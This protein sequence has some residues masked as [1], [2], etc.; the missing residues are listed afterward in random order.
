MK[1][2]LHKND[3]PNR[4]NFSKSIAI[5]T[6]TM[7]LNPA[8][9]RLC[10]VQISNGNGV[11]H[12]VQIFDPLLRPKNLISLLK[13]KKIQKIFHY[14]RFDVAILKYTYKINI[15]NIYCTKIASKL[16][17]TFTDKHGY[18]DLCFDLLNKKISKTQQTTDWGSKKL[19]Q[20]QQKYAATDVLYLHKIK[21]EL[22][23][24]L[25]RENRMK[26]ANACF[27]FIKIRTDLDLFGW[28]EQDIF[29]H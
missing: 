1:I 25:I 8:R 14:A 28:A 15:E 29:K 16:T 19:S 7:G 4:L 22:D 12:L 18:Q 20:A 10:L 11:C 13:N 17:R 27:D 5:D 2:E 21:N 26:I 23:K 24:I 3:L 9:D 6:E